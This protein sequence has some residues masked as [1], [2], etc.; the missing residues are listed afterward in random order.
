MMGSLRDAGRYQMVLRPDLGGTGRG[1]KICYYSQTK[2]GIF[3]RS[4]G[5]IG[6]SVQK[7]HPPKSVDIVD[8][9][10][11]SPRRETRNWMS[12][13]SRTMGGFWASGTSPSVTKEANTRAPL[14]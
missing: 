1:R 10:L 6:R 3:P 11:R 13:E 14:R 2:E 5:M 12:S 4:P 7:C 8:R 9:I